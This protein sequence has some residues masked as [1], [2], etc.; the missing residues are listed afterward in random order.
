MFV[1][2]ASSVTGFFVPMVRFAVVPEY[3]SNQSN[4]LTE[5]EPIVSPPTIWAERSIDL[6]NAAFTTDF[7]TSISLCAARR[8]ASRPV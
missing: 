6:M 5:V 2:A 8:Q 4:E 3:A 7:A 1:I